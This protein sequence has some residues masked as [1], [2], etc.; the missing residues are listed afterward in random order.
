MSQG[1]TPATLI[2]AK[3]TTKEKYFGLADIFTET[4][5]NELHHCKIFFKY[6]EGGNVPVTVNASAGTIGDTM[7]NLRQAA[8]GE[9]PREYYVPL[10]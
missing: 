10:D 4:A 3:Q 9:H 2:Y 5:D 8:E 1:L 6:L 7:S